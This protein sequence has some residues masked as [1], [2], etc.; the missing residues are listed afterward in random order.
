MVVSELFVKE[1]LLDFQLK[2]IKDAQCFNTENVSV[3]EVAKGHHNS[4]HSCIQLK[5]V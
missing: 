4:F 2:Y 1:L 5:T 3:L